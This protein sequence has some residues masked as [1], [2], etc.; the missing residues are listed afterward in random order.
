MYKLDK[1][2]E[3]SHKLKLPLKKNLDFISFL[4]IVKREFYYELRQIT[5]KNSTVSTMISKIPVHTDLS[6][7]TLISVSPSGFKLPPLTNGS[8][9]IGG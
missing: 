9:P 4:H 6:F 2:L 8:P 5:E 3:C 1:L 7:S